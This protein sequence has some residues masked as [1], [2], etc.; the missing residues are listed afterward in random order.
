MTDEQFIEITNNCDTMS[1][2]A[3]LLNMNFKTFKKKAVK[4]NCY[5]PNP[6]S[7]GVS[8]QWMADR[9]TPLEE[10]LNGKYPH[11]QSYKL[12]HRLFEQGVKT[13]SCEECGIEQWN[14]KPISCELDHIDGN[15]RNHRLANLRI[16]CPNCHS[17]TS[18]YRGKNKRR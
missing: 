12:K 17:F 10:I 7:K 3:A 1:Q 8:K 13:N 11:Y 18:T 2:A 9:A 4:L 6:G 14:N 15:S 16:L 5:R